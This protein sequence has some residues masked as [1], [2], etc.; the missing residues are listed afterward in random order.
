MNSF[1]SLPFW[2]T[3]VD[4][5]LPDPTSS[6]L[7]SD[8]FLGNGH[9][10]VHTGPFATW[11]FEGG[12]NQTALPL[13]RNIGAAGK[14]MNEEDANF[15]RM[16]KSYREYTACVDLQFEQMIRGVHEWVGGTMGTIYYSPQDPV[17]FMFHAYVDSLWDDWRRM[18]SYEERV[19]GYPAD[20]DACTKYH[21]ASSPMSPFQPLR[22]VDGLSDV[23][24]NLY[25]SYQMRPTC[26]SLQP[27][28][29]SRYMVCDAKHNHCL[30]QIKPDG[31]CNGVEQFSPCY[32]SQCVE[33]VCI[34]KNKVKVSKPE[35]E[36]PIKQL[37]HVIR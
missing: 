24:T 1:V 20:R 14:L 17:F 28:C 2:D 32:Q 18:Q 4:Q 34:D 10:L 5:A 30:S 6:I 8:I 12:L 16:R 7:F 21:F 9:G 3:T 11:S 37:L 13:T 36:K 19:F 23:Y 25:Y 31:K 22:N 26:N 29:L 33:G 15:L 35:Q 27:M